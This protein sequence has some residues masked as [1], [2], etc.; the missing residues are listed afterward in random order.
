M[1]KPI[2]PEE[3]L[4]ARAIAGAK[5]FSAY[6]RAG[7]HEKY[8]ERGYPDYESA[9]AAAD[10]IEAQHSKFGRGAMV[11]A[12]TPENYSIDC[13]PERVAL[14]KQIKESPDVQS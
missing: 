9:R 12:I 7:P 2:H 6:Y 1:P 8:V 4:L 5:E 13:S 11:Y 14:A 10:R 3:L